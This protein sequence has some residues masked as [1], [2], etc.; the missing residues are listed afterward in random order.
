LFGNYYIRVSL[1]SKLSGS[2]RPTKEW[3]KH[4]GG[5]PEQWIVDDMEGKNIVAGVT[6]IARNIRLLG[7]GEIHV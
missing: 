1:L 4:Y 5:I 7:H 3:G 2:P 6:P